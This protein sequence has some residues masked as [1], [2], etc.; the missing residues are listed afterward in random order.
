[1]KGFQKAGYFLLISLI[2]NR[3]VLADPVQISALWSGID[4][5][6]PF[7]A[8]PNFLYDINSQARYR[9]TGA[10]YDLTR[11]EAGLGY[12]ITPN[13]SGW[14]GYTW[15]VP[16]ANIRQRQQTWQQMLWQ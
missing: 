5:T 1:M 13:V 4:I 12:K 11:S 10:D 8:V 6:G 15:I 9:F 14:L 16:N 3:A 7:I 2:L